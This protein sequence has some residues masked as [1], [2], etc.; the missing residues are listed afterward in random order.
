MPVAV[1]QP[2]S[3]LTGREV[4]A[5][6]ERLFSIPD[7]ERPRLWSSLE[8]LHGAIASRDVGAVDSVISTTPDGPIRRCRPGWQRR[9]WPNA[10]PR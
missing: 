4:E 3:H 6:R 9:L 10:G 2:E 7:A 8:A 1:V 5:I